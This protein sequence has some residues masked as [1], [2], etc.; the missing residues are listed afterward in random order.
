MN[1]LLDIHYLWTNVVCDIHDN[2]V[3][4]I[5]YIHQL[6]TALLFNLV[7][8]SQCLPQSYTNKQNQPKTLPQAVCFET[9]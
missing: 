8:V 2:H 7:I 9:L 3:Y 6:I 1:L 5:V 4:D